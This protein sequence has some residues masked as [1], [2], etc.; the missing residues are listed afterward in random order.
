MSLSNWLPLVK[1]LID[2]IKKRTFNDD[3]VFL[4]LFPKKYFILEHPT[5]SK[6]WFYNYSHT[7]FS[8]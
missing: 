8:F 5:I 7:E 3:V 4:S 2:Y 1:H 6:P